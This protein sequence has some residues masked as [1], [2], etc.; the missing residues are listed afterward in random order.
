MC[1]ALIC[2]RREFPDKLAVLLEDMD[3]QETLAENGYRYARAHLDWELLADRYWAALENKIFNKKKK[4]RLLVITHRFNDPPLGG[5][6]RYLLNVIKAL[7]Q[8]GDFRI[9]IAT[10]DIRNIQNKF[11]FSTEFTC[12]ESSESSRF[13]SDIPIHRFALDRMPETRKYLN[14]KAL[15]SKWYKEFIDLSLKHLDKYDRPLL[16]GGWNFPERGEDGAFGIWSSGR[17]LI[18]TH[19]TEKI[20]IRGFISRKQRLNVS[21]GDEVMF[22]KKLKGAFSVELALKDVRIL[23]LHTEPRN[24]ED[25]PRS[26]G[27]FISGI[28]YMRNGRMGDIRLDY[29]YRDFLKEHCLAEYVEDMIWI[30]RQRDKKIDQ[31]FRQ[32]RGPLSGELEGWLEKHMNKYDVVIGHSIPFETVTLSGRYARRYNK[33][34]IIH[35]FFHFDDEFYHWK[36]YYETMQKA[37][38]VLASPNEAVK[39]FFDKIGVNSIVVPGGGISVEEF[40][41]IDSAPFRALYRSDLPFVLVLGRKSGSKNYQCVIEA[42]KEINA[43]KKRLNVVLIGHDEDGVEID[44]LQA[45]YLG[46]QTRPV[47]LGALKECLAVVNMSESESFGIV[48]LEAWMMDKPVIVNEKCPAFLELVRDNAN[49]FLANGKTLPDIILELLK[50]P[51]LAAR[52]GRKGRSCVEHKYFWENIGK[53][54][55]DVLLGLVRAKAV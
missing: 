2:D 19:G 41:T 11:H 30:A 18:Y 4:K 39:L 49:G 1:E 36:S 25:D 47:V 15:F 46:E 51:D 12:S 53:T 29:C 13:G 14:S 8:S 24:H 55:N 32:T 52:V 37:D 26:L 42:V 28:E 35:P 50:N 10:L 33:P 43:V 3:L 23:A 17:S 44:P 48:I 31:L 6:E 22:D 5:A 40:E 54:I 16:L 38:L 20:T 27:V 34:F 7:D 9:D 45:T 21:A